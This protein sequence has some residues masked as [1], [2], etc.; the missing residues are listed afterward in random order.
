MSGSVLPSSA[1]PPAA[2]GWIVSAAALSLALLVVAAW[3][4]AWP[5]ALIVS[6]A[7]GCGIATGVLLQSYRLGAAS[8]VVD[9][10][11][12]LPV[13]ADTVLIAVD[14]IVGALDI[15]AIVLDEQRRIL[16][17]NR[18]A[19]DLFPAISRGNPLAMVSRHPDLLQSIERVSARGQTETAEITERMLQ[20]RRFIVTSS[21]LPVAS[22][23]LLQFRDTSEQERLAQ[24][25]ADFIANASHE[26]R[27]PLASIRGF[28]ET[29]EGPARNDEGARVRFLSIMATQAVRMNRILDD[30]LSLS[31]IEM[32]AHLRPENQ[33]DLGEI[34]AHVVR[35]LEPLAAQAEITLSYEPPGRP[36]VVRGDR[37][38]L[39]QV[40]QNLVHNA[41][42]Y[43]RQGGMVEVSID[44]RPATKVTRAACTV[45]VRDDGPGIAPEHLPRLTERFY[46]VDTA[47]SRAQGG[48]G[49]GLAIVKHILNR[50]RGELEITS[51]EGQGSQF[52]V[53]LE[54]SPA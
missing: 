45:S 5:A 33:V 2:P 35:G 8:P 7:L 21:P 42:K 10:G 24:L 26:L 28:I 4:Q 14:D 15:P 17:F 29:L 46:R 12:A 31:R 23:L 34:V 54:S 49:L 25:R 18:H 9:T 37:D 20:G 1:T 27:T 16:A 3:A 22:L 6:L 13:T 40:M 43:G 19:A 50:H 44:G 32:R 53:I 30:L 38:E 51:E 48:T 39:E 11:V 36:A 41:I 52:T 47:R